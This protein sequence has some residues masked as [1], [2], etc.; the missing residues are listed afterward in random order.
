M[1]LA[2]ELSGLKKEVENNEK[3]EELFKQKS[4][5]L[6]MEISAAAG[7]AIR[8]PNEDVREV[9]KRADDA[10]YKCKKLYYQQHDR[11]NN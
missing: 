4:L 1:V 11:R 2:T 5:E 9:K 8:H 7:M 6:G 10:M 3:I